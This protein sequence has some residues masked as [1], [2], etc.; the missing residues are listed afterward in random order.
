M[1]LPFLFGVHNHQP[2]GN[3]DH[4]I[5]RLT[6]E[7]YRP[8]LEL[9]RREKTFCFSLHISGIL[10][11]WWEKKVPDLIELLGEMTE[12]GQ[13]E[14]VTGGLFEPVLSAIPREDRKE[15][16]LRHKDYLK[17]LFGVTP[18]GL[19]LTERVWEQYLVEDLVDLG[20]KYVVVD[21]RHFL[22]S[23]FDKR[24][25]YGYYLTESEGRG[26]AVFPI[27]EALR[28]AIPFWQVNRIEE[29]LREIISH[30]G[31]MAIYF[32][33]GEKFGAWPGTKKWVYDQGW[34]KRF[35]KA[36]SKWVE[37]G[38]IEPMTYERALEKVKPLGLAYLPTASY[39]E[40]EEWALPVKRILEFE[41][42]NQRL[43]TDRRF[44]VFIR[45]GH[46]KNF[47]VKYSESNYLHKR[48]L[49]ISHL[50]RTKRPFDQEARLNVL[51]AQ[52][53]DVYWHG[54]FG[55]LYLP[56]LRH[57]AWHALLS[58]ESRLRTKE[59]GKI[60][61]FDLDYDG[62]EE[63][64]YHSSKAVLTFKPSYG[65]HLIEWSDLSIRHNFQNTIT[66]RFEAYHAQI[67]H[68]ASFNNYLKSK[69]D[70]DVFSIHDIKKIPSLKVLEALTYDWYERHSLIEHFFDP[71][72]GLSDFV[73][74]GFN[75]WGDFV[76]Q[77]FQYH[78]TKGAILFFRDGGLYPHG[79]DRRPILLRKMIKILRGGLRL[80]ITY[81]LE[82][83]AKIETKC[84]FGIEFNIFPSFMAHGNG[85]VLLNGKCLDIRDPIETTGSTLEITDEVFGKKWHLDLEKDVKFFIFPVNTVSQSEEDYD[86]T[87]QG[88]AIM[89][90][91]TIEFQNGHHFTTSLKLEIS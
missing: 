50:S 16:I 4:V 17:K 76:N 42:L 88:L 77:P 41:E 37:R 82:Y 83:R 60:E 65:A 51:A 13:V 19:W 90:F 55:G 62:K 26:L 14:L 68:S 36:F 80:E 29:Y 10:L 45:G 7:C 32:D 43:D 64:I 73:K 91:W 81:E 24:D 49:Q 47:L 74:C 56:H 69:E 15:Q 9:V 11:R 5:E 79:L 46:W 54:I 71:S 67:K 30:E 8:F 28:Y 53:N 85:K 59:K 27:D 52:C 35:L 87:F 1:K 84:N 33:D 39:M 61:I 18:I 63:I 2:V 44:K 78:R 6:T 40:M 22:V 25:L 72:R 38:L 3:F 89:P 31:K 12:A 70:T 34:L 75:E 58:A 48:V 23:G 86:L 20:L 21:D 57:A 66:R